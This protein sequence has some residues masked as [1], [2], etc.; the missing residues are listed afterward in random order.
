MP[1][2]MQRSDPKQPE[3]WSLI[4]SIIEK[5]IEAGEV[6]S[7]RQPIVREFQKRV[8]EKQRL[9]KAGI[10]TKRFALL[11]ASQKVILMA[12]FAGQLVLW[13]R[14]QQDTEKEIAAHC[15]EEMALLEQGYD[16]ASLGV[17]FWGKYQNLIRWLIQKNWL[18]ISEIN[19][20]ELE[21]PDSKTGKSK[22]GL[23]IPYSVRTLEGQAIWDNSS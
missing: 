8:R 13:N 15:R 23:T 10:D 21:R 14:G 2:K 9:K 18:Q 6:K 19:S 22:V 12:C 20:F 16:K 4:R 7:I 1:R 11:R 3:N 5:I 17:A